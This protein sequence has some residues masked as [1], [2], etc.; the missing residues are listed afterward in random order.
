M[1]RYRTGGSHQLNSIEDSLACRWRYP[2]LLACLT[3][4]RPA[5]PKRRLDQFSMRLPFE[6]AEAEAAQF[7]HV[8]NNADGHEILEHDHLKR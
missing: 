3:I 1:D 8:E 6:L 4:R 7:E 5:Q 2:G